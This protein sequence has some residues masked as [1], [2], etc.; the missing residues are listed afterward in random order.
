MSTARG[1]GGGGRG[2]G[3]RT[4]RE[5]CGAGPAALPGP[6]GPSRGTGG[7]L[8]PVKPELGRPRGLGWAR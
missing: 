5:R 4:G 6:G 7:G 3:E 8:G 1:G 2:G